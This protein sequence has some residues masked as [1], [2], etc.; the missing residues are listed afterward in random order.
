MTGDQDAANTKYGVAVSKKA[1]ANIAKD[2]VEV[3]AADGADNVHVTPDT[4]TAGKTIYKVSVDKTKLA[5]GD[6]TNVEG[7]GTEAKPYKV[8]VTGDLTK[9]TSITNTAGTGKVAFGA[10]GVS[11]FSSGATG[12][13]DKTVTIDGKEGK[14]IVGNNGKPVTIDGSTGYITGLQNT[15]LDVAGFGTSNRAATE[16]QLKAVKDIADAASTTD[17]RLIPNPDT[18]TDGAYKPNDGTIALKV[19]NTKQADSTPETITIKDVASKEA[20]DTVKANQWDLAVSNGTVTNK[21]EPQATGT[22]GENKRIVLKGKDGV[23]VSQE[24]GVITIGAQ[25][26]VDNDT[27]TTVTS[28]DGTVTVDTVDGN[29]HAYNV[30]VNTDKVSETQAFIYVDKDGNQ[31]FKHAD[32]K[33]YDNKGKEYTDTVH[34]K[35][36]TAAPQRVDNVGSAIDGAKV[37]TDAG[38]EKPNATYLEKLNKANADTPNAAVNVSDLKQASDTSIAKAVTDATNK[39]MKYAGDNYKAATATEAEQNGI[40]KKLGEQLQILGGAQGTLTNNNIGVIA[41][42]DALK[43]KLAES[44]TNINSIAGKGT[45]P[46]TISNGGTTLTINAPE[47]TKPGTISVGGAKITDVAEGTAGTDAVNVSQ[48]NAV[49]SK[50]LHIKPTTDKEKYTVDKNGDVIL[51]YVNGDGTA[52]N[53]TKAVISGVAKN[54]LSNITDDGKKVIT[55]LGT[56]IEAGT[57]ITLGTTKEDPK[58]GQ[59]T[60]VINADKQVESVTKSD[61]AEGDEN[62]ATVTMMDHTVD[63]AANARYGVGVSKKAVE[64]IAKASVKVVDGKN[65]TVTEGTEG[66]AKTY[67]VNVKGALDEITSITN[68]AGTGK[69]AFGADGVTTFS[70]GAAGDTDK[71]VTINGKAGKVIVG[72]G[73]KPVTID[74]STGYVTG[75]QNTTLNVAGFGTS[76]RAATEEQLKAVKDIAEAASTTDY[77]LIA[78]PVEGSDG[79]YKVDNGTIS[80]K[81]KNTKQPDST[82]ET[83]TIN[84][85][86]SKKALDT[87]KANQWDLAVKKDGTTTNVT[88]QNGAKPTDN[89][90]IAIEGADGVEVTQ[91]DGVIKISAPRGTDHDTITT[92]TS[93]DGTITVG[94]VNNVAHNYDIKVNTD[95][96][97]EAQALIFVDD[98]GKQ[99]FKQPD[100]T[101]KYGDGT[102]YT[103]DVHTKVNTTQPQRVDNVGSAIDPD[104]TTTAT[105]FL[106]KL[107]EAAADPTKGKSAVNVSD[108][109]KTS[110]ASIAKA[111]EDSTNKGMKYAGDNY[112]AAEGTKAEQNGITKKLGEQLQILGG[113][114]DTLTE[115]N[116]GVNADG[117]TLKVQLAESLTGINSIAGKGTS[118]LT[119]SNGGTTLTINAPEGT[120]PGTISVGGA[121]ITDVAEGTDPKDAVNV[122][123]LTKSVSDLKANLGWYATSDVVDGGEQATGSNPTS[124]HVTNDNEV[125]FIAGKN[126]K[127]KQ[128]G[129]NFTYSLND[130]ITKLSKVEVTKDGEGTTT[131]TPGKVTTTDGT[132]TTV[133]GPEGITIKPSAGTTTTVSLTKDGLDNGGNKITNVSKGD[134][135]TDAVNVKQLTDEVGKAKTTVT[136]NKDNTDANKNLSLTTTTATDGHTNY[137]VRL[138]DKVTLGTEAAKQVTMDGTAGTVTAGTGDN[139]VKV[140]GTNASVTAG[141]GANAVKVDG[142]KGQLTAAGVVVG[143]QTLNPIVA[144]PTAGVTPAAET[145]NYVTGLGN[146]TWNVTN[147]TYVSGRAATEDQ[148]K[149]V[150]DTVNNKADKTAL[151]DLAIA[152]QDPNGA[153]VTP[154]EVTGDNKRIILKGTGGVTITQDNGE[155]T[156]GAPVAGTDN[157]TVTTVTSTD[158]TVLTAKD[159]PEN[160]NHAYALT[161]NKQAVVDGAQLPVVY[162]TKDGK[163]VTIDKDG[164][165]HTV[166]NPTVEVKPEDVETRIQSAAKNTTAGDTI[167]NNVGSAIANTKVPEGTGTKQNPTFLE[168]LEETAKAT[169]HPNAAVNVSDLKNTADEVV[170]KGMKY[171]ANLGVDGGKNVVANKLGSTVNI[172]GTADVTNASDADKQYDGNN[173]ITTVK[174]DANG[175]TTVTVKLNKDLTSKSLTTNTVTVKG[176]PGAN[177]QDGKD[178]VVTVGEKGEKGTEGKPGKDGSNGTIGVNG[179]DGSAVVINGKDGSIGLNGKDGKNGL[180]IKGDK[181]VVGVDGTDGANGKDGMT[182]IVYETKHTDPKTGTETTVTHQVATMDDGL[183]FTGNNSG[184]ENKHKLNTLVNIVGEGVTKEAV[185]TFESATGNI[186]VQA[187]G[188]STLT[189]K[190]NK[191]LANISSITNAAGNGKVEFKDNGVTTFSSGNNGANGTDT[192]VV[193]NGKDGKVTTGTVGL[194]GKAGTVKANDITVGKQ[195][196][197]PSTNGTTPAATDKAAEGNFITGLDNKEWNVASPSYVSGRAATEDQLKKISDAITAK[198][199]SDYRLV[200]NKD[201][202]TDGKYKPTDNGDINLTVLSSPTVYLP[203]EPAA[204]FTTKR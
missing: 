106:D 204:G 72:N 165:F 127:I 122:S 80:L 192:P 105:T 153:K 6:N 149:T 111:V 198:S 178:A 74:G 191:N 190:M 10:D 145:G 11:T 170:A 91:A 89:K 19:K 24:N 26:G 128:D 136:V 117:G 196:V 104:G 82:P 147:P 62:I 188:N 36:N 169:N 118:P 87:V 23:T 124:E 2:A 46:L 21:V 183:R 107:T 172:V 116:I 83:I 185:N 29:E 96:V 135:D 143:N 120:K 68:T 38:Q 56:V 16:E 184:T 70:S 3:K 102:K 95:K 66:T 119:I 55:G 174:Q 35:V 130:S 108:L 1:V 115:N 138:A 129:R 69:V 150:T 12:N 81:V 79:A 161:I 8:N 158:E 154:K 17:F 142:T 110:D 27:V 123:Q 121:K 126:L 98:K 40:T 64:G 75:L 48:L 167:L 43:V 28:T 84:D 132:T 94:N 186:L 65:T 44:L 114:T 20:L 131:I 203:S 156:I 67:A 63:K 137:D 50:E 99:V 9:I 155:I 45:S 162:T 103:G 202:G 133:T 33:F 163:K 180:S 151:W 197:T 34:T 168:R 97:S 189:V 60:Y 193:I 85:V 92:V 57:G 200:A 146:T 86:A 166:D 15:T 93:S 159:T 18:G 37:T 73:G 195:S 109:K 78:N 90:R 25:N 140:D 164:K 152:S 112:K 49:A 13:T 141:T 30:K 54:D 4:T 101:F 194:D 157:N 182:R 125:A 51:T 31:V 173:V 59:K 199:G 179:K 5:A 171:G 201:A 53:N 71:T 176:E 22:E 41:E 42:G 113:A 175:D 39:G 7:E 58:T 77:R 52:V 148:L 134:A 14:V 139:I 47:G 187:D 100:G 181:G 177:G 88:P 32:G 61:A 144:K 76:N 160:G